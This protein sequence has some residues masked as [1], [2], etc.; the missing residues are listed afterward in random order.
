GERIRGQIRDAVN[1][2]ARIVTGS[3]DALDP[4]SEGEVMSPY[5]LADVDH[6]M[7]VMTRETFG[8][9]MPVMS[10]SDDEEAVRLANDSEYGL[11]ASVWTRDLDR[12]RRLASRLRVGSCGIN[13][14]IK[15]VGAPELPFGG[16][17]GSGVGRYHGPEGLR[18]FSHTRSVV[19]HRPTRKRELNWFP[20]SP[21]VYRNLS[22][23]LRYRFGNL[24]L[25]EKLGILLD[26]LRESFGRGKG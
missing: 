25:R 14:V 3:A 9:V 23:Y 4:P 26:Q 2:G 11:G 15:N 5:I 10:F 19:I 12:G 17:G 21:G 7:A 24:S 8:P 22:R 1:K 20:F 18:N 6:G 13:D 16:V